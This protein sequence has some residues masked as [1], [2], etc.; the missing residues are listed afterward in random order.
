MLSIILSSHCWSFKLGTNK[1][2]S[3]VQKS[4]FTMGRGPSVSPQISFA[5]RISSWRRV[6]AS[7]HS[8]P[9][10]PLCTPPWEPAYTSCGALAS[11]YSGAPA[12]TS[13]EEPGHTSP[14]VLDDISHGAPPSIFPLVLANI[15]LHCDTFQQRP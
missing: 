9:S 6:L 15:S 10:P 2:S 8:A 11:I 4:Q 1:Y 14:G 5:F 3:Y 13:H 7:T 12:N